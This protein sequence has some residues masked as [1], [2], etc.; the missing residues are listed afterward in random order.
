MI[1]TAVAH[2]D[3]RI[4]PLFN[5]TVLGGASFLNGSGS[6]FK[7][8]ADA[9]F[10]PVIE[11]G[12]NLSLLPTLRGRY[13]GHQTATRIVDDRTLFEQEQSHGGELAVLYRVLP[14]WKIILRG[15]GQWTYL[16]ETTDEKWGNGLYDHRDLYGG[17]SLEK[18]YAAGVQPATVR[19]GVEFS[20]SRFPRYTTLSS[21]TDQNVSGTF[22]LD[23]HSTLLFGQWESFLTRRLFWQ[24]RVSLAQVN[25]DDQ[26]VVENGPLYTQENRQD[27]I[28]AVSSRLEFSQSDG[29]LPWSVEAE[30]RL[31]RLVSNQG[32]YDTATFDFTSG[33]EDYFEPALALS[34]RLYSG[35]Y[36]LILSGLASRRMYDHRRAQTIDGAITDSEMYSQEGTAG[37]ELSRSLT[38]HIRVLVGADLYWAASNNKFEHFYQY[39]YSSQ[40]YNVGVAVEF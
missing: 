15:G 25:F 34:F 19:A 18:E 14:T 17:V 7:G 3:V 6:G 38:R 21:D 30:A 28:G 12:E 22:V 2:A 40:S 11:V 32:Y 39:T 20:Q 31:S 16:K 10:V 33:Y 1:F 26:K 13:S 23:S 29:R 27:H 9:E 37:L 5:A 4:A 35:P 8:T 24:N 36:R